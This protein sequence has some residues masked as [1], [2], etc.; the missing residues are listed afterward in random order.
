MGVLIGIINAISVTF[1][2]VFL[3]K[4]SGLSPNFLTW[5][6][7]ASAWPLLA[8]VVTIF[9]S[10]SVPSLQFWLI[11]IIVIVP[12]EV[13]IAYVGTKA[14]YFSPLSIV[15][16]LSAFTS[17]FLIPVGF[18]FLGELPTKLGLLG[19]LAISL[20]SLALGGGERGRSV[21]QGLAN[22]LKDKGAQLALFGAFVSSV[23]I[24]VTKLS[25]NYAPPLL[26][27]FYIVTVGIIV[28]LPF[29]VRQYP[30]SL[31]TKTKDLTGLSIFSGLGIALHFIGISLMPV[32][33]YISVKRLSV[34]LN[35]VFGRVFFKEKNIKSRLLASVIMVGGIVLIALG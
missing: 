22:I 21:W 13:L 3:K 26:S 17:I 33:Y 23:A 31:K 29:F 9:S 11:L 2:G 12:L 32:A 4:L 18:L 14:L 6:R 5:L 10:W 15:G 34:V 35:V 8:V 27:A 16:T 1:L 20:G 7:W 28:L 25:F 24:S 30:R 19:V